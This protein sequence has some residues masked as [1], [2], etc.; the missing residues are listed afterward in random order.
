MIKSVSLLSHL[1]V[2]NSNLGLQEA[3]KQFET[4]FAYQLLKVMGESIGEG[5]M[6]EGLSGDF[7]KDMLFMAVAENVADDDGLGIAE[8]LKNQ[9]VTT[10]G[11]DGDS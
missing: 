7:Y 6:G 5:F 8:M 9:I 11:E 3:C 10:Q 1:N 4:I 2:S